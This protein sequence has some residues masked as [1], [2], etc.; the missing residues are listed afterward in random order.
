[1]NRFLEELQ[2]AVAAPRAGGALGGRP[3]PRLGPRVGRRGRRG[4]VLTNAHVLR[5]D[6][7][8]VLARRPRSARTRGG[9][10]PRPRR[11]RR[12]GRHRRRA[13]GRWEPARR[14][15]GR[16]ARVR[17]RR[18]GR[19]RPAGH[20]RAGHRH[21]P[22]LP[23][24]PRPPHRRLDRALRAAAARLIGRAAGRPR[25][26][27]ARD[28]HG[29]AGGRADARAAGR[30]GAARARRQLARGEAAARP[31]LGVALAPPRAAARLRA[32]VGLPERDGLL[33]RGVVDGGPAGSAR[34]PARRP[35]RA[36]GERALGGV[37][38]LF[39]ALDAAGGG[40]SSASCA[41]PRSATWPI[42][43]RL[44]LVKPCGR[45]AV[46][47]NSDCPVCRTADIV[48]GKWTLLVIRDLAEGRSRFC[49]LERSLEGISPRTLSLR[50][51]ALEE[52]GIVA[53]P[54]VP[55]GPAARRVR[56][57]RE[58]PRARA[59]HRVDARLRQRVA[60][61]RGLLQRAPSPAAVAAPSSSASRL[62]SVRRA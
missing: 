30:R 49:E 40:W 36:A 59:D 26:A 11:R 62:H 31:R 23:R 16:R 29:A 61:R 3:R 13:A 8:A 51:R 37:D 55:R 5:G 45:L 12:R 20:L 56:A 53:A 27:P 54:D 21:G 17:A 9:R 2:E 35:A 19:P 41:A 44:Q 22:L 32:A 28:Q 15:R 39:D 52:E 18:P 38:D 25:R 34:T 57:D 48:C 47:P 7:V 58:G 43:Q 10:R 46:V 33:V 6:E 1:M 24:A 4:R 14:R 50:L 42:V 60:R